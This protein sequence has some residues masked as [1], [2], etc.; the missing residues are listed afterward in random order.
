ML[1]RPPRSTRTDTLFPYT[2]LFR[3]VNGAA[4]AIVRDDLEAVDA[5]E[6]DAG[7]IGAVG[8]VVGQ[9]RRVAGG[10]PLLAVHCAGMAADADVEVDDQAELHRPGIAGQAGHCEPPGF[11]KAGFFPLPL[12]SRSEEQTS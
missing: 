5:V 8:I 4:V 10:V 11:F 2:T 1:R 6:P 12:P 7:G 9:R 3:S